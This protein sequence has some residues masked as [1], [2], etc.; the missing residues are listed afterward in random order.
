MATAP[1]AGI[2]VPAVLFFKNDDELDI[3]SIKKHIIRLAEGGVTGILVQGSNG[4]AQ[5]LS[6]EE[7]FLAIKTTRETLNENGFKNVIVMAGTGAP[8]TKET[9]TLNVEAKQAGADYVL[10]LTPGVWPPQMTKENILKFH[11]E[12]ADASPLPV[13]IYNFPTVCAGI[14]LDSDILNALA[15]H[16]NIVGTKL[17]CGSI[18][19]LHRLTTS[20]RMSSFAVFAG[21]SQ[22]VLPGLFCG[23]AGLIGATVNLFPKLHVKL[24]E[25]WKAGKFDEAMKTQEELGH[26]D[27]AVA[28]L[29]G[30]TGLKRAVSDLFG[31]GS[32]SVRG[33]L[34]AAGPEK[35]LSKE[36]E[37]I[38]LA[39]RYASQAASYAASNI[40][41]KH[42][43]YNKQSPDSSGIPHVSFENIPYLPSE[44]AATRGPA[45]QVS[46]R[47]EYTQLDNDTNRYPKLA[48]TTSGASNMARGNSGG[49]RDETSQRTAN[50]SSSG[51][52]MASQASP[53]LAIGSGAIRWD[54]R[55]SPSNLRQL[56]KSTRRGEGV[57][58]P[59]LSTKSR[60]LCLISYDFPWTI[61]I[62]TTNGQPLTVIDV[63]EALYESL[64][65]EVRRSEWALAIDVQRYLMM[66]AN[67]NRRK[68][69]VAMGIRRVDWLGSRCMF[70]GLEKDDELARK[71]LMPGDQPSDVWV[72]RFGTIPSSHP[73]N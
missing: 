40:S 2:Y 45:S 31:Y 36:G 23:S 16:P 28:K 32:E 42:G 27:W 63:L 61:A 60:Y 73:T 50:P 66:K 19:K 51:S 22:W 34:T 30:V 7:R 11:R 57:T 17:S 55:D 20:N 44:T 29:G 26:T 68:S 64:H 18:G 6:H 47:S 10:V 35:L 13:L 12:V 25:L 15:E 49:P 53:M 33:P 43:P 39:D 71:R 5:H 62:S 8:S 1:P 58:A 48:R 54:V 21:Q 72:V 46:L 3:L 69:T 59:A 56:Y 14:D 67:K 52:G 24:Y 41:T 70:K 65:K 4:E 37:R 38:K 9:K